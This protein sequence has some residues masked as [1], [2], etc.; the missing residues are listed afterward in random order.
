[1]TGT[2]DRSELWAV[3]TPQVFRLE[4]LEQALDAPPWELAAAT[5][6][7]MLVEQAGGKVRVV[8]SRHPNPK[9]TTP[10]DLVLASQLLGGA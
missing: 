2:L 3:Q 9:I 5:D 6:D 10:E 7:A 4:A 1:V 8:P